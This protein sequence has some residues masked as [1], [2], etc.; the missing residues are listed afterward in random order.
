LKRTIQ[1]TVGLAVGLLLL[2]FLFRGV[3]WEEFGN[4]LRG[5]D[6]K[7]LF[8]IQIPLWLSFFTRILRWR[9]IVRATADASF[10][11]M[12]SATQIAFLANFTLP[13]RAGELIRPYALGRLA[14]IPFSKCLA[15][16]SLDR[17]TDLFGLLAVMI[18]AGFAFTPRD[19]Q[20]PAELLGQP[21]TIT[22]NML[23]TTAIMTL[24]V[25]IVIL[26]GLVLLYVNKPFVLGISNAILGRVSKR[27]A[28]FVQELLESFAEGLH[29]FRSPSDMTKSLAWSLV[30]WALFTSSTACLLEAFNLDWPWY[31]PFVLQTTLAVAIALPGAPGFI[32][33]FQ[34]GV[35]AGLM[36]TV[37]EMRYA[38]ALALGLVA[39]VV[40]VIPVA[41]TGVFCLAWEN[42]GLLELQRGS[43]AAEAELEHKAEEARS[44]T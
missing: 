7:W 18:V 27:F 24:I 25:P 17:V 35:L 6:I 8:L 22:A 34:A 4:A 10:R 30:T 37:P 1:I 32:G 44:E 16:S 31:T 38:D 40:N 3:D 15:L 21:Y 42:M 28:A 20:I 19:V 43:E 36:M 23:R 9:Y 39:H 13:A 2:Y 11:H 41:I 33:Q 5:I 29:V 12:F 26:S 14:K